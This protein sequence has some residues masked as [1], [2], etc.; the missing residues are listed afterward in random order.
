MAKSIYLFIMYLIPVVIGMTTMSV[1]AYGIGKHEK[2]KD[3]DG[4]TVSLVFMIVGL[5]ISTIS[6]MLWQQGNYTSSQ[7]HSLIDKKGGGVFQAAQKTMSIIDDNQKL[8]N[9]MISMKI[10]STK[11]EL[12]NLL[13]VPN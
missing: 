2:N 11:D 10:A 12:K 9:E 5:L 13:D 7:C 8:Q 6:V 1:S 4:Y 3:S